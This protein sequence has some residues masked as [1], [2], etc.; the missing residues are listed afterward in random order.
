MF[1][2]RKAM[3]LQ[4]LYGVENFRKLTI[5]QMLGR[6]KLIELLQCSPTDI[7]GNHGIGALADHLIA[8]DVVPVVRCKDCKH[9]KPMKP[10]PNYDGH[11]KYCCRSAYK[12]VA[13]NDFCS[14]GERKDNG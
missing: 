1:D 7:M 11:V 3:E 13:D 9:Y 14:W 6:E 4:N 10:L 12:K 2:N 8:N 5:R